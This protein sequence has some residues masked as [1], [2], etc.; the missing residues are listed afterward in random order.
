MSEDDETVVQWFERHYPE[1]VARA[2]EHF[3]TPADPATAVEQP[4][5]LTRREKIAAAA[6]TVQIRLGPNS[7]AMAE[8]G[9]PITL[10]GGEADAL[11]YGVMRVLL[12][13]AERKF[14]TFALD[15]AADA[16]YAQDGFTGEDEAALDSLRELTQGD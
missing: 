3:T 2:R 10:S 9:M 15:L 6:R 7:L 13:P 4:M 14:L 8:R 1:A 5:G 11:S 12:T 16:M